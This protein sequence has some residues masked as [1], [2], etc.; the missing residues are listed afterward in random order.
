MLDAAAQ[1]LMVDQKFIL[2]GSRKPVPADAEQVADVD[3][4]LTGTVS[5]LLR[6][7][8]DDLPQ[9]P[10]SREAF[11]ERYGANPADLRLIEKFAAEHNL[12]VMN[13]D[14]GRRTAE[15]SGTMAALGQAFGVKLKAFTV[16]GKRYRGHNEDI[17]L[18]KELAGVVEGVFGLDTIPAARPRT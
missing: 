17:A 11:A 5:I 12:N 18:P 1:V 6:R 8:A 7:R 2:Q 16:R 9:P 14:P 3:P 13:F 15:L 4:R 10:L